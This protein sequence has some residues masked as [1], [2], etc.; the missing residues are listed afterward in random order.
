MTRRA[1]ILRYPAAIDRSGDRQVV[2]P[3]DDLFLAGAFAPSLNNSTQ[4]LPSISNTMPLPDSAVAVDY[5]VAPPV[6]DSGR[7]KSSPV[8]SLGAVLGSFTS[9]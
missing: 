5:F 2:V 6:S 8:D 9:A 7:H 3:V 1:R 4:Y